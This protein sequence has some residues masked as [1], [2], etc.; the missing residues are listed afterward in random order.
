MSVAQISLL[1]DTLIA[2]FLEPAACLAVLLGSADGVPAR[3]LRHALA[4]V[5]L[6]SLSRRH[7]EGATEE[8]SRTVDWALRWILLLGVPASLGLLLLA[9]AAAVH[10]VPHGEFRPADVLMA[11][12]QPR[13]LLPG[14]V[15]FILVKVLAPAFYARQDTRTPVRIA[16][17]AL[18]PTWP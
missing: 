13:G 10:P 14:L 1:L 12:A 4:T 6:P 17:V 15:G 8:F 18:A 9:G 5:I 7:A 3:H 16:V 11:A 2:S